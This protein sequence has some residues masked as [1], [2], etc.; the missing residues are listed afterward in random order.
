[1]SIFE[2]HFDR[3]LS[4]IPKD[5]SKIDL[6]PLFFSFILNAAIDLLIGQD[7]QSLQPFLSAGDDITR[8]FNDAERH[9]G[10]QVLL[11]SLPF[12]WSRREYLQAY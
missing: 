11:A 5:G 12:R 2:K 1:M 4:I 10:T 3:L 9:M 6:Q 8:I 7:I